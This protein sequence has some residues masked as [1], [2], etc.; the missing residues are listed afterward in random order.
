MNGDYLFTTS[1]CPGVVQLEHH[2]RGFQLWHITTMR[3]AHRCAECGDW[4]RKGERAFLPVTNS[5]N[6]RHRLHVRCVRK[7]WENEHEPVAAWMQ[8]EETR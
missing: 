7:L 8:S 3:K 6:R 1:L 2:K 4:I 5:D